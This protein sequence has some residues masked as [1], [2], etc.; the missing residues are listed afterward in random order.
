MLALLS[1]WLG[2]ASFAFASA[3]V[4]YRRLFSD[5]FVTLTLYA[6][7]TSLT[8]AGLTLWDLRKEDNTAP[9]VLAR[10]VQSW[11]GSFLSIVA[12]AFIY[13]LI[14]RAEIIPRSGVSPPHSPAA[15]S[16]AAAR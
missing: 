8:F 4:L 11:V 7:I 13:L 1:V 10:R 5:A 16:T 14:G 6:A 3:V 15:S 12:I 2:L 9:G